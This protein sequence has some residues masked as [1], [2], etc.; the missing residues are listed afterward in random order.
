MLSSDRSRRKIL[1]KLWVLK[2]LLIL[3]SV[4]ILLLPCYVL[5][6]YL[7]YVAGYLKEFEVGGYEDYIIPLLFL[8]LAIALLKAVCF[9]HKLP[10]GSE[11]STHQI[12]KLPWFNWGLSVE[13]K[14]LILEQIRSNG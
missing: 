5:I 4:T 9:L 13:G 6:E 2:L 7:S 1:G 12:R 8:F 10:K 14:Y 3:L 11:G